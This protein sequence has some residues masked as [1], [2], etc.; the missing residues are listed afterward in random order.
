M[1]LLKPFQAF[2]SLGVQAKTVFNA[3]NF[4]LNL[5]SLQANIFKMFLFFATPRKCTSYY[6]VVD[7]E[8]WGPV[9]IRGLCVNSALPILH[10]SV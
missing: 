1:K 8:G 7:G 2:P 10:Y 3:Y 4:G 9:W 6:T 5:S